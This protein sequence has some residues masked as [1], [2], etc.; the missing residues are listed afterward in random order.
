MTFALAFITGLILGSIFG[1]RMR[2]R[3]E[4]IENEARQI[5]EDS[6]LF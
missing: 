6:S 5:Q 3:I 2:A 1:Y 4:N